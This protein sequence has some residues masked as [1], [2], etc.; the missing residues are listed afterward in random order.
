[1]SVST[2]L[3]EVRRTAAVTPEFDPADLGLVEEPLGELLA[4]HPALSGF[5][6]YVE[7]LR[8]TGGAHIHNADFSLGL[9]GVGGEVVTA[10][11]EGVFLEGNRYFIF[12]EA[13]YTSQP[14]PVVFFAF[15]LQSGGDEVYFRLD[16]TS[17]Y[18]RCSASF[19][20]FLAGF[21]AGRYPGLQA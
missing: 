16:E 17:E 9:Y 2:T 14:E 15:D 4:E 10:F 5:P 6:D 7:F 20:E 18:T 8:S 13:L 12:G 21:G 1:M 3:D 11:D 19:L